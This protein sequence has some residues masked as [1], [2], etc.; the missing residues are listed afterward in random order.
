MKAQKAIP[1]VLIASAAISLFG[2][3]INIIKTKT[4]TFHI[5]EQTVNVEE[6]NN[7]F[8]VNNVEQDHKR[9]IGWST[10]QSKSHII[11][12]D[13]EINKETIKDYFT[14]NNLDLYAIY[15][16]IITVSFVLE[17]TTT[18]D[19]DEELEN[20]ETVPSHR[21][22]GFTFKGWSLNDNSSRVDLG[23]VITVSY[24]T[25]YPIAGNL[26]EVSFYP[27]YEQENITT[28]S[29]TL[30]EYN[31]ADEMA[32]IHIETKN[33]LAIDDSS[34]IKKDEHKG[35]N[36]EVPVYDYVDATISVNH[37]EDKYTLENASGKVKVRGNYTS[38]YAKKPIRIKFSNKQKMLGLNKDHE[39]KNWV[40][41]AG[42]KDTSLLRDACAFYLG[43]ALLES[44]GYYCS[45]FRF[46]K[47]YL[48]DAYNGV[49][50][51]VEQ[52]QIDAYRVNIPESKNAT[53]SVKTGY[54]LEFDG[55][56]QNEPETQR[57]TVSYNNVR[58]G[59][60]GFTVSNDIMNTAQLN[61]VKKATQNIW[62]VVYD[63]CKQSHSDLVNNPYHTVNIDGDYVLDSSILTKQE[64]IDRVIDINSLVNMYILH[65]ILED[66]DI[67]F[68]SFYFAL[69]Y[70]DKGSHKLTFTAPWD[71]DYAAGNNTWETALKATLNTTKLANDGRLTS[72]RRKLTNSASL[73]KEDFTFTN[74]DKLY[75]MTTDNPWFVVFANEQWLWDLVYQRW[76]VATE[77]G[78]FTSLLEMIDVMTTKYAQQFNENFSKWSQSLGITLSN[79]Q[80]D[81]VKMFVTQKQAAQYLRIW[82]EARIEGLAT[83]LKNKVSA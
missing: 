34:L 8:K 37:C 5:G 14:S 45:D 62:K 27:V 9:F 10:D 13:L 22:S 20:Q 11:S 12:N 32:E 63:A 15:A 16:N 40:L 73:S 7:L 78:L 49:Y 66:R 72:N 61:F 82:L 83:A 38:T 54:F 53:D 56:Y 41:L 70:S 76:Q 25:I 21:K 52:Q 24:S 30:Y 26:F 48:N 51:L 3:N 23:D 29:L 79:Y 2:C 69:D 42:W 81:I 43:N 1:F 80:P 4:I 58:T 68:S 59:N 28:N 31:T 57:F 55:Y 33:H 18:Y 50:L 71:F 35:K 46:V 36:G 67:G 60:N 19:L 17:N 74:K 77:K 47:V 6:N 65:E 75:C 39:L 64:A 44:D